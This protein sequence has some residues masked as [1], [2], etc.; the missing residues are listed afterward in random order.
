MC[1]VLSCETQSARSCVPT[2]NVCQ[3]TITHAAQLATPSLP[4]GVHAL[5][6]QSTSILSLN[7]E[8]CYRL[9]G[10]QSIPNGFAS[11][12]QDPSRPGVLT[13]QPPRAAEEGDP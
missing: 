4:A 7:V 3:K 5:L 1:H 9:F 12:Q 13:R 11:T 10:C 6:S 2:Y 8:G